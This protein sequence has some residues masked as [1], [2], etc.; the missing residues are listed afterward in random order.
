[1]TGHRSGMPLLPVLAVALAMLIF[2]CCQTE[3]GSGRDGSG[4]HP[5]AVSS[6]IGD[7]D[8]RA[9]ETGEGWGYA[10]LVKGETLV[11]QPHIP[12]IPGRRG[13]ESEEAALLVG[14]YVAMKISNGAHP[15]SVTVEEMESLGVFAGY[16]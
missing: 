2:A 15:P 7:I 5:K 10:V 1:M 14:R 8:V 3:S 16:P 6:Q 13:F 12:A 4:G 9:F 11:H